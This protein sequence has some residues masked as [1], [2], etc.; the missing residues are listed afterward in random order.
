MSSAPA[1]AD[2]AKDATWLVQ[3]LDARN[4]VA[5][6][7]RMDVDSYREASFLDDRMMQQPREAH[8]VPWGAIR[9]ALA[10]E[11]RRDARWIFHIGHVGST[12]VA[13]LLGEVEGVLSIREPR[14]LRDV[15][16]L[17]SADRADYTAPARALFSRTF[18]EN[19]IALVKA[20]SFVSEIA[21]ELVP[22]GQRA[23]FMYAT[24]RS[25]VASILAGPNSVQELAVLAP[26]RIQRM[27]GRVTLPQP[28]NTAEAAAVGWA[29]EM[30]ALESAAE[31]MPDRKI[32]WADFDTMLADMPTELKQVATLFGFATDS[33]EAIASGPLMRRYSKA[34][35]Y[36]YS[37]S[38]RR[39]LIAEAEAAHRA[40]LDGALAML[41]SAAE[42][43]PLLAKA[44]RRAECT[45]SSRS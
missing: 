40:D 41:Q 8:V 29:C 23:L 36:E 20:T 28:R 10:I 15:A 44:L 34:T 9:G 26:S 25:Y 16:M 27:S 43:S 22:E 5:R 45:E 21:D 19:E 11:A 3:A 17:G 14:F 30:T 35:E 33:T 38:L 13:R 12:L 37:P 39:D 2:I 1:A 6:L 32:A 7:V 4:G 42:N 31:R 18:G 24:P